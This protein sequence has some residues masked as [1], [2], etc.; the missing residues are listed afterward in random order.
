MKTLKIDEK[1]AVRF[2]PDNNDRPVDV[3]RNDELVGIYSYDNMVTAMFYALLEARE[4]LEAVIKAEPLFDYVE[5][6]GSPEVKG[7]WKPGSPY[8]RGKEAAYK[9]LQTIAKGEGQ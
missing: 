9:E 4:R 7:N 1:W 2:D 8:D 5:I 3:Y 6:D